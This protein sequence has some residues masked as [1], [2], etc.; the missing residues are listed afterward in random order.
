MTSP[1][2]NG[3]RSQSADEM[4]ND[5]APLRELIEIGGKD[6]TGKTSWI[7]SMFRF[8][9]MTNP[10][11]RGF[12]IDSEKK[13]KATVRSFGSDAPRNFTYY[14]VDDMQQAILALEQVLS[15]YN[16]GD[17]LAVE[18]MSRIWEFAQN[19]G[20]REIAGVTKKEYLDAKVGD[21]MPTG[22]VKKNSPVP[23]AQ[24]EDA[25]KKL[26]PIVKDAHDHEFL[27][28]IINT[29]D[30][31]AIL[32][33]TIAKPRGDMGK[34]KESADRKAIRVELGIDANL[35]GAPRLPY[36][37]LTLCLFDL[38][39][40]QFSCQ[41]LR[42]NNSMSDESRINFPITDK[43]SGGLWFQYRCRGSAE[44]EAFLIGSGALAEEQQ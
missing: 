29:E 14:P 44:A 42:D 37:P 32:T 7:I 16:P 26:W 34:I 28:R 5:Q 30:L 18:S 43:K 23:F 40:G 20:Y 12:I 21:R 3:V 2:N 27:N 9:E 38:H 35:E 11:A 6:S 13:V 15:Q 41:V 31:N 22:V 36:Q 33:T 4:L 19:Y 8:L 24:N 1:K 25:D 10:D 17:W 39:Q